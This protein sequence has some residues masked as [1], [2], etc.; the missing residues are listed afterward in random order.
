[1]PSAHQPNWVAP[2]PNKASAGSVTR[3]S[4]VKYPNSFG[5]ASGPQAHLANGQQTDGL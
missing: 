5:Q 2:E 4:G 1:M 3:K